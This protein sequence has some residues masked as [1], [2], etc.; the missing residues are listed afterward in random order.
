[1]GEG[2]LR[3]EGFLDVGHEHRVTAETHL[4]F[5]NRAA[6]RFHDSLAR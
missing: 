2:H 6:T 3:H 5:V 1:M 4:A